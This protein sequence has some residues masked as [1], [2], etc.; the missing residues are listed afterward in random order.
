MFEHHGEERCRDRDRGVSVRLIS[1]RLWPEG[2]AT[3]YSETFYA[4]S[5]RSRMPTADAG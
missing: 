1:G 5:P 4:T 2:T 3:M